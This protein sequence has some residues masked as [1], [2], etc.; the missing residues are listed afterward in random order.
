M[1]TS[2]HLSF[3]CFTVRGF[4][5]VLFYIMFDVISVSL[6]VDN[7]TAHWVYIVGLIWGFVNAFILQTACIWAILAATYSP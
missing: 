4:W 7:S 1:L 6:M 5:G 2:F 3:K